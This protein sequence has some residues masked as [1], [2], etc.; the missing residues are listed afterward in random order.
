MNKSKAL[1]QIINFISNIPVILKKII[2]SKIFKQIINYISYILVILSF[3][4]IFY[5]LRKLNL[6]LLIE[7]L[8]FYW[9]IVIFILSLFHSLAFFIYAVT[10]GFVVRIFS[11]VKLKMREMIIVYLKS[12]IAKYLP[13]NIFHFAGRHYFLR[14][15]GLSDESLLL[16]NAFEIFY[17]ILIS[18]IIILSAV[19]VKVIKIPE[20]I[21]QKINIY[22]FLTLIII[23]SAAVII[24]VVYKYLKKESINIKK[25]LNRKNLFIF[26]IVTL[27]YF[28]IF[29]II[30]TALYGIMVVLLKHEFNLIDFYYVVCTYSL[31]WML[32]YIVPGAPGGLGIRE[33]VITKM[34]E[35][36]FSE[37]SAVLAAIILRVVTVSGDIVSFF[38]ANILSITVF[39]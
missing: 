5:K 31:A 11:A 8:T 2:K 10:W 35:N 13:G 30:G 39:A 20:F 19:Y 29:I 4:F 12:N 27:M 9:I 3:I 21:L 1:K 6:S 7:Q 16:S 33:Y 17:T 18:L 32:G 25:Y 26:I 15:Q 38:V 28:L 36:K 14:K 34:L 37:S 23:I 24:F 22:Y